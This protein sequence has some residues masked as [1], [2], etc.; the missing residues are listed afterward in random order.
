MWKLADEQLDEFI[1]D[2]RCEFLSAYAAVFTLLVIADLLGIPEEY[3]E[4]LRVNLAGGLTVG[5]IDKEIVPTNP[6]TAA[7]SPTVGSVASAGRRRPVYRRS[8]PEGR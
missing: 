1:D 3:H 2:S 4:E 8:I 5:S 6:L 7:P